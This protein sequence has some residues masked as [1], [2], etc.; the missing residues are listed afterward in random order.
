MMHRFNS[1]HVIGSI[2]LV[3]LFAPL[4]H[5]LSIPF[6]NNGLLNPS[7]FYRSAG[8]KATSGQ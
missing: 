6:A 5:P 4:F 8:S 7:F 2:A 3:T 1:F